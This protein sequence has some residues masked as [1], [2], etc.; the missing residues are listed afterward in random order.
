MKKGILILVFISWMAMIGSPLVYSEEKKP[1]SLEDIGN[2]LKSNV[3]KKRVSITIAEHGV[4]FL[5][6]NKNVEDLK[7]LG[8]DETV[9]AAIEKEWQKNDR[10][11]IVETVP[12]NA[13]LY[14]DG[15]KVGETPLEIE[16]LKPKKYAVRVEREGYER[17]D[18]EISL[19][20][21]IGRKLTISLVKSETS[22][23][24]P[25]TPKPTPAPTPTPI[26]APATSPSPAPT[27]I[28]A[29]MCSVFVNTHPA[30]AKVYVDGKHYGT[31]PKYIE[32]GAGEHFIVMVKEFYKP[33][34]KRIICRE[35][36]KDL[37]SIDQRLDPT[38]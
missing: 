36:E 25:P 9:F 5:K 28:P 16:G 20:E 33:E 6:I 32:L 37:P 23:S 38:R 7:K 34:E 35:G 19:T 1:L 4:Q 17:V 30:G 12:S 22:P 31:S 3:S 8:A 29:Q 14:L 18:H 10:V 15:E 27:E 2:L 13:T 24:S 26:P 11:L 21:G